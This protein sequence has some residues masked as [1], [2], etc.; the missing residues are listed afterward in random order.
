MM[1]LK[2]G[3]IIDPAGAISGVADI[4]VD[5]DGF[6]EKIA[7]DIHEEDAGTVDVSGL[8]VMPGL[9]DMHVHLREPG[10]EYKETIET[11]LKAAAAGGFTS[12][13]CMPNTDPAIDTRSTVKYVKEQAEAAGLGRLFIA[14]AG[15]K[16]IAGREMSEIGDMAAEG[17]VAVT[18]DGKSIGG[19]SMM[20]RVLEYISMF[21][22]PYMVH[23]ELAELAGGGVMHEGLVSTTIGMPGIPSQ[24]ESI[25]VARDIELAELTGARLHITHLSAA[26]SLDYVR[27]AKD[28]GL[29]V[30][31][32][33]TPHH[34]ALT[35]EAAMEFDTNTKVNPP[36]RSRRHVD[37][38]L[39]GLRDGVIDAIASDHAP[40]SV[41][42]KESSYIEAPFGLV[43][44][45]TS[46]AILITE[47]VK[48][49]I[50][51]LEQLIEKLTT[52]PASVLGLD[53]GRLEVGAP[54]DITVIDPDEKWTINPAKFYS[55]GRNCPF[56][57]R[58]V[59]GK[60]RYTIA[61]GKIINNNG[62]VE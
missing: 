30:T 27:R 60:V 22:L 42:E 3:E 36:L 17:I 53:A 14:A 59:F 11:G 9:I 50:L 25:M 21:D 48:T 18:D 31:C 13:V 10:Y 52:G 29:P 51:S 47:I 16:G 38:L 12:V 24:A 19:A 32:D 39:Q 5:D 45:E 35:D 44:L 62:V 33:V 54:A 57:G 37:A 15:T 20:R 46:L 61:A 49:G 28:R 43:G 34:L 6:I 2:S 58:E 55:L 40:H 7:P 23:A 4:L 1:L 41:H 56:G 8:K 26:A